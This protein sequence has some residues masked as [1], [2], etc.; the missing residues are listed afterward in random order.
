MSVRSQLA[1]ANQRIRKLENIKSET[2]FPLQKRIR[3][4]EDKL[5]DQQ[6]AQVVITRELHLI[7]ELA[8]YIAGRV[9]L[10]LSSGKDAL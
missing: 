4:L 8:K 1:T 3:E 6:R 2:E 9:D 5:R 7:R 10:A